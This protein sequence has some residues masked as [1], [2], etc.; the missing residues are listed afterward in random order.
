[1]PFKME[2]GV[3]KTVDARFASAI[4]YFLFWT[5]FLTQIRTGTRTCVFQVNIKCTDQLG[6]G[7]E[8]VLVIWPCLT[9][10]A[11]SFV[12]ASLDCMCV[13]ERERERERESEGEIEREREGARKSL[14]RG[15]SAILSV[16]QS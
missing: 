10:F 1:M 4:N 3:K 11:L 6:G 5:L 16:G 12:L 14:V 13:C 9:Q 15:R 2:R 7:G 8:T